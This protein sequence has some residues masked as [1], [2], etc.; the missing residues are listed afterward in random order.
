MTAARLRTVLWIDAVYSAATG[1]LFLAGSWNGLYD[2]LDLPQ[3]RPAIFVQTGGA[4]LWGV[5]YLLW[6]AT[7]TVSLMLPV[8]RASAIMNALAAGVVVAW[9]IHGG[10]H[11]GT[12]GKVELALAAALMTAFAAAYL[13]A[14]LRPGG[15]GPEPSP[16]PDA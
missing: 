5:A 3:G 7:R 16:S 14:G 6:L 9:L 12:F 15:Y 11:I 10:L 4:V 8:A 1:F 13:A 2:A